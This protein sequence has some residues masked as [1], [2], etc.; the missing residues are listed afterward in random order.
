MARAIP[1]M[2]RSHISRAA[3]VVWFQ[4]FLATPPRPLHQMRFRCFFLMSR[5]PLLLLRRG[6]PPV[7]A[8]T[9]L[10]SRLPGD[11]PDHIPVTDYSRL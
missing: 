8:L 4:D 9:R 10:P 5:P 11:L 7:H 6:H 3:G 2:S 1:R